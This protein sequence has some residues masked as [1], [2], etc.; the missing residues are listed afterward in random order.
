GVRLRSKACIYGDCRGRVNWGRIWADFGAPS[1]GP[2]RALRSAPDP[3]W[4]LPPRRQPRTEETPFIDEP[5]CSSTAVVCGK[6][7]PEL[8]LFRR[9][10]FRQRSLSLPPAEKARKGGQP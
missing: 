5:P 4:L 7:H 8:C 3:G 9:V 1:E 2:W 10:V 6:P